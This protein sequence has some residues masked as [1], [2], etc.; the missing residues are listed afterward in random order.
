M[1]VNREWERESDQKISLNN[2]N[3]WQAKFPI[4]SVNSS[5]TFTAAPKLRHHQR[6]RKE[7][8]KW[9]MK[10]WIDFVDGRLKDLST[11]SLRHQRY[12]CAIL[13]AVI[14]YP[15]PLKCEDKTL[16]QFCCESE[17]THFIRCSTDSNGCSKSVNCG[18]M[19]L[20]TSSC[21][22]WTTKREEIWIV[23]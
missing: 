15:H 14:S 4:C 9:R 22:C 2:E 1:K 5:R 7:M 3:R 23:R 19:C 13:W 6:W 17:R 20:T 12:L 8:A 10:G 18:K 21:S 16:E 11:F